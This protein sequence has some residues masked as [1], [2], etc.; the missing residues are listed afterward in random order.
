MCAVEEDD[1]TLADFTDD[2]QT[3]VSGRMKL[4]AAVLER[5]VELNLLGPDKARIRDLFN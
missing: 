3:E 4:S 5:L 2:G 1:P